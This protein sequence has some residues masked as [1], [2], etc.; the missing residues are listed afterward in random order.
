[1]TN[2][3]LINCKLYSV[4]K[5]HS[6]SLFFYIWTILWCTQ[7]YLFLTN[8]VGVWAKFDVYVYIYVYDIQETVFAFFD[9]ARGYDLADEDKYLAANNIAPRTT[10]PAQH[11]ESDD[12]IVMGGDG[13]SKSMVIST[14]M[15]VNDF[16]LIRVI[17]KG[18]YGIISVCLSI[19]LSISVC[20]YVCITLSITLP[21]YLSIYLYMHLYIDIAKSVFCNTQVYLLS[22]T[23][24]RRYMTIC[25]GYD[26]TKCD[27]SDKTPLEWS[28]T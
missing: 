2:T 16:D 15:S 12:M 13:K 8:I 3:F 28:H 24:I 21:F 6:F 23:K 1:M 27:A 4:S 7:V 5:V 25:L 11:E 17:G 22:D 18:A 26:D 19:Y 9:S 14:S 20:M 10:S